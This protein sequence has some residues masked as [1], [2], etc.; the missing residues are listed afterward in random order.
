GGGPSTRW[1][2]WR[3]WVGRTCCSRSRRRRWSPDQVSGPALHPA[4]VLTGPAKGSSEGR[5]HRLALQCEKSEDTLV[6]PEERFAS[7][8]PLQRLHPEGKLPRRQALLQTQRSSLAQ[9]FEI[10]R[11]VVLRTVDDPKVLATAALDPGLGEASPRSPDELH[12][13][14]DHALVALSA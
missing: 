13:L 9:S 2:R 10:A 1:S 4:R 12:R 3:T 7:H 14:D 6:H 8:E 5:V 11:Q